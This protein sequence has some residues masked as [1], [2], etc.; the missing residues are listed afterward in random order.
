MYLWTINTYLSEN[1]LEKASCYFL[2][3]FLWQEVYVSNNYEKVFL[4]RVIFPSSI[5]HLEILKL[6]INLSTLNTVTN[7]IYFKKKKILLSEDP[8][9]FGRKTEFHCKWL[10]MW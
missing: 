9:N 1:I 2:S 6:T 7:M 8:Q 5:G 4:G 10:K 3:R